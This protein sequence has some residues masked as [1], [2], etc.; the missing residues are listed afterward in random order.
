MVLG[1]KFVVWLCWMSTGM[2]GMRARIDDK[3]FILYGS[4]FDKHISYITLL[5]IQ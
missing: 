3:H 1:L 5:P 4:L 2:T